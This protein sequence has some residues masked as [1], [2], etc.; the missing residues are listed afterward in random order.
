MVDPKR[1]KARIVG[2]E[3]FRV[4]RLDVENGQGSY[5]RSAL[6]LAEAYVGEIDKILDLIGEPVRV[7]VLNGEVVRIRRIA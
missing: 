7:D 5:H 4:V 3:P 1:I 2:L 6:Q